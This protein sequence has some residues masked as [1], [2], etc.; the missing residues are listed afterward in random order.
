[1][2]DRN[3]FTSIIDAYPNEKDIANEQ[4]EQFFICLCL[5]V[6]LNQHR[7]GLFRIFYSYWL[8]MYVN[9]FCL[10]DLD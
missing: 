6:M 3:Q 4:D 9:L 10:D 5:F 8:N 7:N 2:N 1:M